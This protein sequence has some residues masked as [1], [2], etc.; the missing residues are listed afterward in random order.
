MRTTYAQVR[1]T[2][3]ILVTL[4]GAV[5]LV[6]AFA[7][8]AARAAPQASRASKVAMASEPAG[9]VVA[10]DGMVVPMPS[11]E[12]KVEILGLDAPR[13]RIGS[14]SMPVPDRAGGG[15]CPDAPPLS[16]ADAR[17]LV[18]KVAQEED[19]FPEFVLSVATVESNF[20]SNALSDKG[21]YG[22]MQLMPATAS[23]IGRKR[24]RGGRRNLLYQPELNIALGQ[25]YIRH[26]ID[27]DQI[28]G[29]LALTA[30]AY[31]GGPGNLSKWRKRAKRWRYLDQLVFIESIPSSETR[32]YVKRVLANI[33]VYRHRLDQEV[34]SLDTLAAGGVPSY[35]A[36]DG[37]QGSAAKH[38]RN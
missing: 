27:Q 6:I 10:S 35:K 2:A 14:A 9:A 23:F 17:A 11:L 12:R 13:E 29:D 24:Y 34:P 5:A 3:G 20:R 30:A 26:L 8:P 25:K 1:R 7:E 4:T 19:F 38:A 32:N 31:N 16:E 33:W 36:L 22:L 21:A 18:L 37:R 15:R 28:Q